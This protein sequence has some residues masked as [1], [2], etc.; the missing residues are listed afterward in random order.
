MAGLGKLRRSDGLASECPERAVLDEGAAHSLDSGHWIQQ[1]KPS[2]TI[3]AILHW[4]AARQAA[5][6]A[7]RV[8]RRAGAQ[9]VRALPCPW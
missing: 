5:W 1:E 4:P 6:A 9:S 3:R 7:V 2:E 8:F